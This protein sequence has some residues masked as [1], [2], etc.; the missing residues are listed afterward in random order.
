MDQTIKNYNLGKISRKP[1]YLINDN[2]PTKA[3]AR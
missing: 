3:K 1:S 2:K